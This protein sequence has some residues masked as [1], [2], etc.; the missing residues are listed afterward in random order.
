[1]FKLVKFEF[2]DLEG[3]RIFESGKHDWDSYLKNAEDYSYPYETY[4]GNELMVF[5]SYHDFK[6]SFDAMDIT[7]SDVDTVFRLGLES[8]GV[9]PDY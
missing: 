4:H 1:M 7:R 3:V 6:D 9:F 5:E 8:T 2:D